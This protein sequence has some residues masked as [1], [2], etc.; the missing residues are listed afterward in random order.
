MTA[1][2]FKNG[3][4]LVITADRQVFC[5]ERDK[6]SN[7][8]ETKFFYAWPHTDKEIQKH[9]DFYCG[10]INIIDERAQK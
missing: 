1:R 4:N 7:R 10:G 6:W 3:Q 9:I 5:V 2:N 8:D